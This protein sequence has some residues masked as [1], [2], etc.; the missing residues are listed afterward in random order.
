VPN[1][2]IRVNDSELHQLL[3]WGRGSTIPG[4]AG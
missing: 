1:V 4:P 2:D 3:H